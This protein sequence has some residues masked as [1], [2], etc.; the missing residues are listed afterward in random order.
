[1]KKYIVT[2]LIVILL[3]CS[4]YA[5][6]FY[7]VINL[8]IIR[9]SSSES[10]FAKPETSDADITVQ[11][12]LQEPNLGEYYLDEESYLSVPAE[13][14]YTYVPS[15]KTNY[16]VE[17]SLSYLTE[18][19]PSDQTIIKVYYKLETCRVT[20]IGNGGTLV[21]GEEEQIL[22]KGQTPTLPIYYLRGYELTGYSQEIAPVYEDVSFT[23]LWQLQ[24]YSLTLILPD[25]A[26]LEDS[27]YLK[28]E[29]QKNSYLKEFTFLTET[30]ALPY[31]TYDGYDFIGW[32]T[33]NEESAE[34]VFQ[35][36]TDTASD[37]TLYARFNVITY[38]M[39]FISPQGY[40]F[41]SVIAPSGSEVRSPVIPASDQIAGYGLNWYY[42]QQF[43]NLYTFTVMPQGGI[44]LYGKW[45]E[46][47]GV[48]IFGLDISDGII[49]SYEEFVLYLDYLAFNYVTKE[50]KISVNLTFATEEECKG[51]VQSAMKDMEYSLN[52][53]IIY[54]S[55]EPTIPGAKC[56]FTAYT[57]DNRMQT[58]SSL[59]TEYNEV[60][61]YKFL[62]YLP[63]SNR[64]TNYT[65]YVEKLPN[66]VV[67]KSSNQLIYAVEHG[68]KPICES[69]SSA[70]RIFNKAKS[71]LNEIM[72]VDY[73]DYQKALAIFEYLT[74]NVQYDEY[75]TLLT[76]DSSWGE[77]D[78]FYLEGVFD[79]QKAVC[80]G[81]SK[82]YS[83]MCNMEGIPCLQVSG[84]SH[85][86]CKV[87]INNRWTVIDPTHGNTIIAG[88]KKSVIAHEHFCMSEETKA[89]LG[90]SS[91][92]YSNVVADYQINYFLTA[93]YEYMGVN[94][95]LEVEGGSDLA[96][97]LS[98]HQKN[99]NAFDGFT[100]EFYFTGSNI[101]N[102]LRTAFF[103]TAIY[104]EYTYTYV[105]YLNG[106]V[107]R[108]LFE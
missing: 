78:A 33:S 12:Y 8:P 24:N 69:G 49:E 100:I 16:V 48:G 89:T 45:E 42:D 87:K 72:G 14:P 95:F 101:E 46:D 13:Q 60:T 38:E 10:S 43:E 6:D 82:A 83:L 15:Q 1:M 22:R 17:N 54:S 99:A 66:E 51:V 96:L 7:G 26:V 63:I 105:N 98:N 75:A 93:S 2:I 76:S 79:K 47:S 67:V 88:T 59:S 86:W 29:Y 90:Y 4:V 106:K 103:T 74:L 32:F 73:S 70:E 44:T 58:E 37:L 77:Y 91:T 21:S 35:I 25:G 65:L 57:A 18:S 39:K 34:E 97:I 102:T 50:N 107:V 31:P 28:D 30:F 40:N 11:I 85:A 104:S 53:S 52:G 41:N 64:D 56:S 19:Q 84:N 94:R 61:P 71:T 81:I 9:D 80:D 3:V 108:L 27:E 68:Y 20:F 5:L 55:S 92:L 36:E 62:S 23:A